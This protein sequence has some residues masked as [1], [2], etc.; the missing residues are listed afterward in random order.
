MTFTSDDYQALSDTL[1]AF[2]VPMFAAERAHPNADFRLICVNA[3]HTAKT[4][5]RSEDVLRKR[6]A[7]ILSAA[8]AAAVEQRY[9]KCADLGVPTTYDERL[10]LKGITADWNTTLQPVVMSDGRQRIIGTAIVLEAFPDRERLQDAAFYAAKAQLQ[11]GKIRHYL[12]MLQNRS[13]VPY[14]LR[15][16]AM[17]VG[18]VTQSLDA[19]MDDIR[20]LAPESVGRPVIRATGP[21]L[22]YANTETPAE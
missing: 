18:S 5:L 21:V 6:T 9:A 17:S 8:D 22:A 14:G 20:A 11:I 15:T 19:I 3:A 12:S 4:G 13:E 16:A 10:E 1:D 7:E 2:A